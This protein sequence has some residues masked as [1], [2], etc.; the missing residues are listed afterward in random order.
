MLD[1]HR[2]AQRGQGAIDLIAGV[3]PVPVR[4]ALGQVEAVRGAIFG[5]AP[6]GTDVGPGHARRLG[7]ESEQSKNID[8]HYEERSDAVI[9]APHW[10]ASLRSQ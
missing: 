9:Q 8:R 2:R 3:E 1:R 5:R 10:I 7:T 6:A 4:L